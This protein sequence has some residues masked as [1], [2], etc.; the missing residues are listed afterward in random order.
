MFSKTTNN[1]EPQI[2]PPR[3]AEGP[4][5][6]P[7]AARRVAAKPTSVL[8]ADLVFEGSIAG[9]G[10]LMIEGL[11]KGDVQ[12]GR[13][14][15]GDR[16]EV[17]GT[18]RSGYVEVRGRVRGDIEAKSV[19]LLESAHVDGDIAYEQL[20]IEVGAFFQGRCQ[21]IA[22][23]AQIVQPRAPEYDPEPDTQA[24]D[25]ETLSPHQTLAGVQIPN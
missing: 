24:I 7:A 12:V 19:R 22:P 1:L 8:A 18:V 2:Q 17:H 14:I 11:V 15:V 4:Q 25:F 16:A 6:E 23:P 21:Q 10:E 9:E 13:L 5:N 20:S 3:R